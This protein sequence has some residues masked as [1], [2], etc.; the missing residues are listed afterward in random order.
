MDAE[1]IAQK[2]AKIF[3][4]K[5]WPAP[6][7]KQTGDIGL[8]TNKI[9]S[10]TIDERDIQ[11][12][13][14]ILGSLLIGGAAEQA[15][16]K[17]YAA[18]MQTS[19]VELTDDRESRSD[20]DYI[21]LNGSKRQLY[22]LNIKLHGSL[23]RSARE[24]VGLDPEDCFPLATYKIFSALQ[25]Q[26]KYHLP[27]LFVVVT[28]PGVGA[29]AIGSSLDVRLIKSLAIAKHLF[30][31]R[32]RETE[33][34]IVRY[35]ILSSPELLKSIESKLS[36]SGWYVFSARRAANLM[37]KNLFTRVFALRQ[38]NF[39]RAFK[40]AEIDM[41]LSFSQDMM[42]LKEFLQKTKAHSLAVVGSL[43]ERGTI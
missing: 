34:D 41:H 35:A 10:V 3:G 42:T 39:N 37:E 28:A 32:K 7:K 9:T 5:S 26:D 36:T 30:N 22:R 13:K 2:L 19:E 11:R 6:Y 29:E 25:K 12:A 17:I 43:I 15:F 27:F 16:E 1:E 40:N 33:E 38:R 31:A 24:Q 8:L 23:F 21:L 20:A 14:L 18:E 4:T